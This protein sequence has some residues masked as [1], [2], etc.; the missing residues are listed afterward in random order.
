MAIMYGIGSFWFNVVFECSLTVFVRDIKPCSV[1][2]H[3]LASHVNVT[4]TDVL[5]GLM[6]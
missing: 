2:A 5:Y 6:T 3:S 1:L 4:L